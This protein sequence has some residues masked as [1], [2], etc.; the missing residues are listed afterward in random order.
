M[1][2]LED[3]GQKI[4]FKFCMLRSDRNI[5]F[6][7]RGPTKD[8]VKYYIKKTDSYEPSPFYLLKK[9]TIRLLAPF[10]DIRSSYMGLSC[11]YIACPSL[12]ISLSI[13]GRLYDRKIGYRL[14]KK[15]VRTALF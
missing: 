13:K 4:A 14:I 8:A 2:E 12:S 1:I 9:L 11:V 15:A 7:T 6:S 5:V 3:F 10:P